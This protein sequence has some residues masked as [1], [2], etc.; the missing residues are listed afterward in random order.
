MGPNKWYLIYWTSFSEETLIICQI[1]RKSDKNKIN[2]NVCPTAW[3]IAEKIGGYS[4]FRKKAKWLFGCLI[5]IC[6]YSHNFPSGSQKTLFVICH[7]KIWPKVWRE[8]EKETLE[9]SIDCNAV[10]GR[11]VILERIRILNSIRF[12][13]WNKYEYEYYS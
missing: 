6:Y 13:I 8:E 2:C 7:I 3:T 4:I 1:F 10:L 11:I 5:I 12:A 9:I